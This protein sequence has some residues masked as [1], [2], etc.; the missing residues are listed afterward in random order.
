MYRSY[1]IS[2]EIDY[3]QLPDH[4]SGQLYQNDG[5]TPEKIEISK[6]DHWQTIA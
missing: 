2:E 4:K 3:N 6:V 1:T 5:A